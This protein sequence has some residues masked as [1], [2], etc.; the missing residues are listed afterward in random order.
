MLYN[1]IVLA[2][3]CNFPGMQWSDYCPTNDSYCQSL[4]CR[5]MVERHL[6][7]AIN[8][9]TRGNAILDLMF[10]S[11]TLTIGDIS[12]LAPIN[13]SDHDSQLLRIRLLCSVNRTKL[14]RHVDYDNLHLLQSQTDW[15]VSFQRCI[16]ADDFAHRFNTLIFS[17]V[18][19]CT[20]YNHIFRRQR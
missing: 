4:L 17:A 15:T 19:M 12:Y 10:V 8:Q 20:S 14:R 6:I 18:D 13:C 2:G 1:N 9:P 16:I 11:D 5:F 7:Q 3:D